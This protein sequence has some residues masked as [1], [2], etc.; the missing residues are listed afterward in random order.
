MNAATINIEVGS[1]NDLK[2]RIVEYQDKNNA[3]PA[4]PSTGY[5]IINGEFI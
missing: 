1:K 4:T 5:M 2:D 3:T